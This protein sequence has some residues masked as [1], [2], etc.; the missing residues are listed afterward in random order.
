MYLTLAIEGRDKGNCN[1]KFSKAIRDTQR[2][3]PRATADDN[4]QGEGSVQLPGDL[5]QER[6]PLTSQE[7]NSISDWGP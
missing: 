5:V 7:V 4:S 3:C 2:S 1:P 6:C